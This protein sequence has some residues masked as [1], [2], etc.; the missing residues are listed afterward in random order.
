[1]T[2]EFGG[3]LQ[4]RHLTERGLLAGESIDHVVLWLPVGSYRPGTPEC[5]GG[6]STGQ[7]AIQPRT[8]GR[9]AWR[10]RRD[11]FDVVPVSTDDVAPPKSIRPV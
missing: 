3:H 7:K 1:M 8:S 5:G 6:W 9:R 2:V 11:G 4:R 10:R